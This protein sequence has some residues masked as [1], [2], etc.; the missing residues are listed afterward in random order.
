MTIPRFVLR[1]LHFTKPG[2]GRL[3]AISAVHCVDAED[4]ATAVCWAKFGE[5]AP[6]EGLRHV[7][8]S[9][10]SLRI[11]CPNG[12]LGFAPI[13]TA[14]FRVGLD[15]APDLICAE[16]GSVRCWPGAARRARL[17]EPAAVA[18][19]RSRVGTDYLSRKITAGAAIDGLDERP[20][21]DPATLGA[22]EGSWHRRSAPCSKLPTSRACRRRAWRR[23]DPRR[24]AT[25]AP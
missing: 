4:G 17:V 16:S 22:T 20:P 14:S 8:L 24:C 9:E 18:E 6:I 12:H 19:A 15:R 1:G 13:K 5:F 23:S 10:A 2:E 21:L 25:A 3:S 7:P 11:L